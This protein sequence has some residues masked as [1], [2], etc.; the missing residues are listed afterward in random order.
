MVDV[1]REAGKDEI[2]VFRLRRKDGNEVW[3]E[4]HGRLVYDAQGNVLY[5]E[6]ILRDITARVKAEKALRESEERHRRSV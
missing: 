4:D 1:L 3:V 6:G 5:H 2:E